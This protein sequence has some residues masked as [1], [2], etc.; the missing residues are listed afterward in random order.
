MGDRM[1]V[2]E[3]RGLIGEWPHTPDLIAAKRLAAE[4][5]V[6]RMFEPERIDDRPDVALDL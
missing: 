6:E 1:G 2:E 4:F 5:L 3:G